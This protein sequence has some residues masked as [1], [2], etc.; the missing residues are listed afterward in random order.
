MAEAL[1][2]NYKTLTDDKAGY[3]A[4]IHSAEIMESIRINPSYSAKISFLTLG[5]KNLKKHNNLSNQWDGN[6][7]E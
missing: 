7:N 3:Y 4:R 2:F 1:P 5:P 6:E